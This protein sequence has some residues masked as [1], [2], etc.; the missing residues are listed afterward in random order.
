MSDD[1]DSYA[2]AAI[3][4]KKKGYR[5]QGSNDSDGAKFEGQTVGLEGDTFIYGKRM[6]DVCLKSKEAF[7][8]YMG[9]KCGASEKQSLEKGKLTLVGMDQPDRLTNKEEFE[10]LDYFDQE[11]W[12]IDMKNYKA[13]K[14]VVTR[15]LAK[16]YSILWDQCDV[17][18][19]RKIKVHPDYVT[20]KDKDNVMS[21]L[22][23][24]SEICNSTSTVTHY[25]ARMM[26]ALYNLL[27]VDGNK[28]SLTDYMT[29]F[30]ERSKAALACGIHFDSEGHKDSILEEAA[31]ETGDK[32]PNDDK[33]WS[34]D[35]K[36][37]VD[38]IKE[39]ANERMLA[40]IFVKRA[41][42]QYEELRIKMENDWNAGT[43]TYPITLNDAYARL[44]TFRSSNK[45]VS[46]HNSKNTR[47]GGMMRRRGRVSTRKARR[48]QRN[49]R[50]NV[51]NANGWVMLRKNVTQTKRRMVVS[52]I[53]TSNDR[54][55]GRS[56]KRIRKSP[57]KRM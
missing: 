55:I 35:Y 14:D 24:I 31:V 13:R 5:H 7:I 40:F 22:T 23:I 53:I 16:G 51:S 33:T 36:D 54:C 19:K 17:A 3:G 34:A 57:A 8:S 48:R 21:L 29:Y 9:R 6:G 32:T 45:L 42:Y 27:Y 46:N 28:H 18:L 52:L 25:T 30:E 26:E 47:S 56:L 15:N 1:K 4:K 20:A 11:E 43:N 44:E 38:V 39:L 37:V 12:R 50:D 49:Y 10:K 2:E 41:G